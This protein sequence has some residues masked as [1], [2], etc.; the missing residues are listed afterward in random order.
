MSL[1]GSRT[2]Q[3]W[4]SQSRTGH[5]FLNNM[6]Y[7]KPLK[8]AGKDSEDR[9]KKRKGAKSASWSANVWWRSNMIGYRAPCDSRPRLV[10]PPNE[11]LTVHTAIILC[12]PRMSLHIFVTRPL[13]LTR[14]SKYRRLVLSNFTNHIATMGALISILHF[15]INAHTSVG[16]KSRDNFQNDGSRLALHQTDSPACA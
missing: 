16:T 5:S 4:S 14:I 10:W 8:L 13:A 15:C 6:E 9:R 7:L 2:D 12:H 3:Y 1:M 11:T